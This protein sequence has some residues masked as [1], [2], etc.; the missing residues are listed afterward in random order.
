MTTLAI[1]AAGL[2]S[3]CGNRL[4]PYANGFEGILP[5]KTV[6]F[7]HHQNT[8]LTNTFVGPDGHEVPLSPNECRQVNEETLLEDQK[9]QQDRMADQQRAAEETRLL[10]QKR[11]AAVA[12][13]IRDEVARGY[14]QATVKDFLLDGKLYAASETKLAVSGFYKLYGRNDQ[15]LYG[16]YNDFMMHTFQTVEAQHIGLVTDSGSRN[17]REY[18]LRCAAAGC[19]IT[20][21]G[22][23]KECV[24]TNVFG[25]TSSDIC[26]VADNMRPPQ[27]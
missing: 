24:A 20:I 26:L 19:N 11:D 17:L 23:A 12:Q 18:L 9:A 10:K 22:Q 25:A 27:E 3:G 15:R 21:L 13:T 16:S 5:L 2:V 14:K 1:A 4:T 8:R 6:C 7:V